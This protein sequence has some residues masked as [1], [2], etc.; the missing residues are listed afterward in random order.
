MTQK[1]VKA[2]L[3]IF[4]HKISLFFVVPFLL[5]TF[6]VVAYAAEYVRAPAGQTSFVYELPQ[7]VRN[8]CGSDIFVPL[9][10]AAERA[11]FIN[12]KPSCIRPGWSQTFPISGSGSQS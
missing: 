5:T 8:D 10:T 6:G 9:K 7:D 3:S 4:R 11:N 12:N 1:I 2:A